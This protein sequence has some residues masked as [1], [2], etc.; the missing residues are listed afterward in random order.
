MKN[1]KKTEFEISAK[2]D[3]RNLKFGPLAQFST[4]NKNTPTKNTNSFK[5]GQFF[6]TNSRPKIARRA[7]SPSLLHP[8]HTEK[9][10]V[11]RSIYLLIFV[12]PF[13]FPHSTP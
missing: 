3:R 13:R 7:H 11:W 6:K 4:L 12:T 10:L 1:A 9:C 2:T 8:F 5:K